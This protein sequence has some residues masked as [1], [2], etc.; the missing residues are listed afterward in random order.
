MLFKSHY[1]SFD[2]NRGSINAIDTHFILGQCAS[3]IRADSVGA[4]HRFT[5]VKL[6]D[7]IAV[8]QHLFS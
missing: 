6:S 3:L 5:G 7:E 1:R 2:F 8:F 4:S